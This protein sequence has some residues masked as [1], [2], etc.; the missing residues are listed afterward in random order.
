MNTSI[1]VL[2][3]EGWR[4]TLLCL[5]SLKNLTDSTFSIVIVDNGS[6]DDSCLMLQRW[7]DEN[8]NSNNFNETSTILG[9]SLIRN[10]ENLGYAAGNNIGIDYSFVKN[11]ADAVWILNNDTTVHPHSLYYLQEKIKSGY[12]VVGSKVLFMQDSQYVWCE[13]GGKYS[14]WTMKSSNLSYNKNIKELPCG[15]DYELKIENDIDYI[16]GASLFFNKSALSKVGNLYE[17][18]FLYFEEP[19]WFNR[20]KKHKIK[21]GYSSNSIVY[22]SIGKSTDKFSLNFGKFYSFRRLII[23]NTLKFSYR[24]HKLQIPFVLFFLFI[25]EFKNAVTYIL[26]KIVLF[27]KMSIPKSLDLPLRFLKLRAENRI[28]LELFW[29]KKYFAKG[30]KVALDIGSNLGFY[31]YGLRNSFLKIYAFEPIDFNSR[32]LANYNS[33]KVRIFNMACSDVE[34][35]DNLHVPIIN[36][37][38]DYAYA[39]ISVNKNYGNFKLIEIKKLVID[40]LNLVDIDF[41]KIDVEGH[42]L[43]VVVGASET[44]KKYRPVI[45]AELELRHRLDA[46]ATFSKY[47]YTLADYQ[48]FFLE[49]GK[50]VSIDNFHAS[51]HQR[52]DING[53]PLKPYVNNFIFISKKD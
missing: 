53:N 37:K 27:L 5:E 2:N 26:K 10:K 51:I 4:D 48:G 12:D 52:V 42:E 14:R 17:G 20:A 22:H 43:N 33:K 34:G 8:S 28:D 45:L 6:R 38:L 16:A 13:A 3:W 31:S 40:S 49:N 24:F 39:G 46:V 15:I 44:I 11:D 29:V 18:Y 7:V 32:F 36:Q 47:L 9:I 25:R 30:G 35:V 1:V 21:V 50:L 23:W 41:I 19:D